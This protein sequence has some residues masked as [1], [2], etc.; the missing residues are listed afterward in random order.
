MN[1]RHLL[2]P[3]LMGPCISEGGCLNWEGS[4]WQHVYWSFV[5]PPPAYLGTPASTA[6]VLRHK[7]DGNAYKMQAVSWEYTKK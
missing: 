5:N 2:Q 3:F 6:R 7:R 4:R 1:I